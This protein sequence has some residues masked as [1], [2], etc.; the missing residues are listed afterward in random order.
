M[1]RELPR[2]TVQD[3]GTQ[4]Y[5]R[6]KNLYSPSDPEAAARRRAVLA[7]LRPQSLVFVPCPLLCYGIDDLAERLPETS[8]LLCV[9]TDEALMTVTLAN[10][11]QALRDH[12]R[13]QFVRTD[14]AEQIT[15]FVHERLEIGRFRR[16]TVAPLNAG[17]SLNGNRYRALTEA[18]DREIRVHWQNRLTGA[19]FGRLWIRNLFANIGRIAEG[20]Q[21]SSPPPVDRPVVV[22]GAGES[23]ESVLPWLRRFRKEFF[24]VAVD[25]A[26]PALFGSGINAD[27]AVAVDAQWANI[28]DFV[29]LGNG[30]TVRVWADMSG[31]PAPL[32]LRI[33]SERSVFLSRFAECRLVGEVDTQKLAGALIPPLGSVGVTAVHLARLLSEGLLLLTGLDFSYRPGKPHA[34]GTATHLLQL[35]KSTRLTGNLLFAG[36]IGRRRLVSRSIRRPGFVTDTVLLSYA[37]DLSALIAQDGM[38]GVLGN[39][40]M[41]LGAEIIATPEQFERIL[42]GDRKQCLPPRGG[43]PAMQVPDRRAARRFL[44]RENLRLERLNGLITRHLNTAEPS[45]RRESWKLL[46][47]EIRDADYLYFDFPDA[48]SAPV[49]NPAFLRRLL[50]NVFGYLRKTRQ[51]IS[52]LQ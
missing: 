19:F 22:A 12:P 31:S 3:G 20:M 35:R 10:L 29:P 46:E 50:G 15:A 43:A 13:I 11:P 51:A 16:L 37:K 45:L 26:L 18:L 30:S 27:I 42:R 38:I 47:Q 8:Q 17:Y 23:L 7:D 40:G 34:R 5:Y 25:T 24:L 48:A 1:D 36:S 28:Q 6:G 33:C 44:E 39:P 2:L 49:D 21:V 14:S 32:R 52:P 4:V 9:E 41:D